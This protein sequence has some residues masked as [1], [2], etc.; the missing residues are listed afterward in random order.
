MPSGSRVQHPFRLIF[1]CPAENAPRPK[2]LAVRIGGEGRTPLQ[3]EGIVRD[4]ES[5]KGRPALFLDD[6]I[7]LVAAVA[8][9]AGGELS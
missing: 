5:W 3:G 1:D 2:T 6:L 8:H 7:L 9:R 4:A